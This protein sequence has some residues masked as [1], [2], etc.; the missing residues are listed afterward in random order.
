[1]HS[2]AVFERSHGKNTSARTNTSRSVHPWTIPQSGDNALCKHEVQGRHR[3]PHAG[4]VRQQAR[5]GP[6]EKEQ[7][8]FS[9]TGRQRTAACISTLRGNRCLG[10]GTEK[11]PQGHR[12]RK[13]LPPPLF[14][15]HFLAGRGALYQSD[16]R[17]RHPGDRGCPD[18]SKTKR[19]AFCETISHSC[20]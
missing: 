19:P 7:P 13:P 5:F 3:R 2:I 15:E 6:R 4:S 14:L 1:M 18:R 20:I 9:P 17:Q 11:C 10:A 8:L 16:V 12:C